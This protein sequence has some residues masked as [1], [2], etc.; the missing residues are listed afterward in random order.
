M[1]RLVDL[2]GQR[3]G[4]LTVESRDENHVSPNG[5]QRTRWACACDCGNAVSVIASSLRRGL[6]K[7]CG[8]KNGLP[9]TDLT[10]RRFG[11][12]IVLR[13]LARVPNSKGKYT[14][15]CLCDCGNIK[16]VRGDQLGVS[17][18]SCGCLF[19]GWTKD[20]VTYRSA[21]SRI[22]KAR[23]RARDHSCVDC[24]SPAAEWSYDYSDPN[25]WVEWHRTSG[26]ER[27]SLLRYSGDPAH[28]SPRCKLCHSAF[29]RGRDVQQA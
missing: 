11:R 13:R 1:S 28:Y 19:L 22:T 5:L 4:I 12:L 18:K 25:E 3:F 7:S 26:R 9:K 23:G 10:G 8:C 29:D 17:T 20:F 14:W 27:P 16:T 21:H 6:T 2:T 24:R 15:E